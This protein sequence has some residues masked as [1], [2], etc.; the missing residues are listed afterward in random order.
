MQIDAFKPRQRRFRGSGSNRTK[1]ALDL[2]FAISWQ[3]NPETVAGRWIR[4]L[5]KCKG[6]P[7]LKE[8]LDL[9]APEKFGT[10][11]KNSGV[12]TR[13]HSDDAKSLYLCGF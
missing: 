3:E 8:V 13:E 1:T 2:S 5:N 7:I 12:G 6:T 4:G 11:T 10:S 9:P